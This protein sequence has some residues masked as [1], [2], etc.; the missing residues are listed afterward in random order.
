MMCVR[1]T[2][3][4]ACDFPT[5]AA[6]VLLAACSAKG[7]SSQATASA[8]VSGAP[9][10]SA[11]ASA[12]ASAAASASAGGAIPAEKVAAVLNPKGQTPYAGPVGTLHGTV[13]VKGDE[14]P[15]QKVTIPEQC[16]GAAATYGKLFRVGQ[17]KTLADVLVAV[18]GYD[19]YVPDPVLSAD[20][21][22][23]DC[24]YASR[25][26]ALTFGQFLSVRNLDGNVSYL[27]L[28]QGG[29][30][31]AVMVATPLGEAVKLY[32]P[33]PKMYRLVDEMS[34]PFMV[35]DVFVLRYPTHA[36][37]QLDG[38]YE[39]KGIPVG[40]MHVSALL[41]AAAMKVVNLPTKIQEGDNTLDIT[42][43]FNA[44]KDVVKEAPPAPSPGPP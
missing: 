16:R 26:Y 13:H 30:S 23:R 19:A 42:I 39:I 43:E 11:A 22:I 40:D 41:P 14:P 18:T 36:V 34:R 37:T 35:A 7:T 6:V 12:S 38:R 4:P 1:S 33:E 21:P 8:S 24:A 28:L 5:I 32:A 44:K 29:R 10:T 2:A 25:T 15:M 20:V 27:P 31:H 3:R 9:S 17:D